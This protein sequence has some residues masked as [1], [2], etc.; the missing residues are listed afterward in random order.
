MHVRQHVLLRK[1]HDNL[2][3]SFPME[4]WALLTVCTHTGINMPI[5]T[6]RSFHTEAEVP[7]LGASLLVHAEPHMGLQLRMWKNLLYE[8][9]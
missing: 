1:Q 9:R 2:L 6:L 8:Q 5:P 3:L 4:Y 7:T